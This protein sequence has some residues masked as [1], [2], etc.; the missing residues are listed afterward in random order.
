MTVML[1]QRVNGMV[2]S[3]IKVLRE[4][5]RYDNDDIM[6]GSLYSLINDFILVEVY[7]GAAWA[8]NGEDRVEGENG[9]RAFAES[10]GLTTSK[11]F[12]QNL[13]KVT[14]TI[15]ARRMQEKLRGKGKKSKESRS[16]EKN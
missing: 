11:E 7:R 15:I 9:I 3:S 4:V 5:F 14:E 2:D 16:I 12:A 1:T 13:E 6:H 10:E 8:M